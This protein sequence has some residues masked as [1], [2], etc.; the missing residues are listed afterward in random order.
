MKFLMV[1]DFHLFLR[2]QSNYFTKIR[3]L[4]WQSSYLDRFKRILPSFYQNTFGINCAANI[5]VENDCHLM[6]CE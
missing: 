4:T 2:L 5:T 6:R 3:Y 1:S